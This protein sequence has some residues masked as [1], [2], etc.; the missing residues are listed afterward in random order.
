LSDPVELDV[1]ALGDLAVSIYLPV[2]TAATTV[3]AV[4]LQ[5]S[6][7]S[8]PGDYTDAT[9]MPVLMTTQSWFLL[10]GVA[11]KASRRV[12]AIAALGDS[13][14]DGSGSTPNTNGRWP[15]HLAER[16]AAGHR[17]SKMAVLDE[18][19]SGNRVLSDGSGVN[20]LA[21]FDRDV[22][23]QPGVTSVIVLEGINDSGS[24]FVADQIIAGLAQL[25]ERAHERGLEIFGGTLTPA[26]SS[27]TREANRQAVNDWTRN[28]GAFDAVIDFDE[29]L[30]DPNNPS[31]FLPFYDSGDHLHPSNAGYRAM[32][33]AIDLSLFRRRE[34]GER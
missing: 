19:I 34:D 27:G 21:R 14:T 16:L 24:V 13:I 6:Y 5:T 17:Q 11:V 23:A 31:F 29:A 32:A 28:S 3:H 30:R 4:A 8:P 22:L 15:N 26:G 20:A 1:P 10:T 7:V 33:D 2:D 9:A 12:G 25:I 18:G